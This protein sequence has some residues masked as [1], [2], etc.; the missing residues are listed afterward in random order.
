MQEIRNMST[1]STLVILRDFFF[2]F[3]I[4][5]VSVK[6]AGFWSR[7]FLMVIG[8]DIKKKNNTNNKTEA[9]MQPS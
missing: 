9:T 6:M 8:Q 5:I 7:S 3:D 4:V 1:V 2:K